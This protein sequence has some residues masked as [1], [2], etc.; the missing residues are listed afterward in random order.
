MPTHL[1]ENMQRDIDRIR[2]KILTMAELGERALQGALRALQERNR[3][4][5]YSVILRDQR[6]DE[7]EK[8]IDRLC[9]EFLVRQQPVAGQLRFAYATIK[10]NLELERV[11]DYAESIARQIIKLIGLNAEAPVAPFVEIAGLAIPMLRDAVRAFVDQDLALAKSRMAVEETVDELR[12]QINAE[13]IRLR[14]ENKI[15]LEALTPLMTIARRFERVSDQAKN[16]CEE[17]IYLCT[18][19]ETKHKGVEAYR[20]LFVDEQN[21]CGSQM[22]EAIGNALGRPEFIFTSAGLHPK[23]IDPATASFLREKG[24]EIAR[25]TSKTVAQVPN[26][27][28]YQIVVGL[29]TEAQKALP[30]PQRKT[31]YFSWAIT[32]PSTVQGDAPAVRKAYEETYQFLQDHI[33]DLMEAI[34]GDKVD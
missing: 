25:H 13:L 11:G 3:Q 12:N 15:P 24:L 5:A 34:L 1:E 7:L 4:L 18:G 22:A 20:V 28:H 2:S 33:R 8:E 30:P 32:D 17:V 6:I 9:L 19:E 27:E 14:Q 31:V 16:I 26:L 29:A 10:I 23:P 21:S